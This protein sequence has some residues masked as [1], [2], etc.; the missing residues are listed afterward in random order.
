VDAKIEVANRMRVFKR[1]VDQGVVPIND[2]SSSVKR[3]SPK[4][5]P[6]PTFETRIVVSP[7][8]AGDVLVLQTAFVERFA[9]NDPLPSSRSRHFDWLPPNDQVR[10]IGWSGVVLAVQ[11]ERDGTSLVKIRVYPWLFSRVLKTL[12]V[13]YVEEVYRF[14]PNLLQLV[15]SDADQPKPKLQMFPVH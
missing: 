9:K 3:A 6:P 10:H 8:A 2:L 11:P 13:D 15:D 1:R 5:E 4:D 7:D 12:V 14:G